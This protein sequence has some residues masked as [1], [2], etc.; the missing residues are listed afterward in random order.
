M[1]IQISSFEQT[2]L[3]EYEKIEKEKKHLSAL[4]LKLENEILEE[5][6]KF[7]EQQKTINDELEKI[8]MFDNKMIKDK[9]ENECRE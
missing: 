7:K 1:E 9:I 8:K 4:A 6:K 5:K 2:K 3:K